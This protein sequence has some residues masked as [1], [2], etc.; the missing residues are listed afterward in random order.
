MRRLLL[1]LLVLGASGCDSRITTDFTLD[2]EGTILDENGEPLAAPD[3]ILVGGLLDT[4]RVIVLLKRVEPDDEGGYTLRY[5]FPLLRED[6]TGACA[7]LVNEEGR[8]ARLLLTAGDGKGGYAE[9]APDCTE[10]RQRL[11][12]VVRD[13]F[14]RATPEVAPG[15]VRSLPR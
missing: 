3:V 1:T 2:L 14:G 10:D 15:G 4:P 6:A 12:L 13:L 7:V 9:V 11:D 5:D 8:Q